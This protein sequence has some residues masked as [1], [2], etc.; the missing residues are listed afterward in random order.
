MNLDLTGKRALVCGS[1]A[2]IGRACAAE[3]AAQ[4]AHVTLAARDR[5]KLQ[6]VLD[7]L[8]RPKGQP[9]DLLVADFA[10]PE[11]VRQAVAASADPSRPWHILVNN[12]G[13]PPA[14]A[15]LDAFPEQ[16]VAA[17]NA[18]LVTAHVLAQ[19]LVPGMK[20][21]S[22]GRIINI[23]STSVKQPI[24]NLAISNIVRPAV[25]AWAK[26][27]SQDLGPFGI[28]VNNVL[29]GYTST[30]RLGSLMEN[31]AKARGVPAE[32][33]AKEWIATIPAARLGTPEDLAAAVAFLASPAAGY[34]NGIN[35][36][37]DGGRLGTL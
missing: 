19:L 7:A 13:G 15:T 34:I 12:T 28:T 31:R 10:R 17:F 1:S 2:G 8:P 21:A 26:C 23:T 29:P 32:A 24:A 37:V 18:Q 11:D 14:G 6:G 25:A 4:G 5:A 36:P 16:L 33:I 22:Y 9:H 3:L 20:A 30:E 27:L 35:L